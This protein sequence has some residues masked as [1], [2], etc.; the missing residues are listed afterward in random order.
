MKF[1]RSLSQKLRS[2]IADGT[3]RSLRSNE[4]EIDFFSNDYLGFSRNKAIDQKCRSSLK[5]LDFQNGST[6]SRLISGNFQIHENTE[7]DLAVFFQ[8]E[9]ALLFNS[10]YDANLGLLSAILQRNDCVFYD[11]LAH[12]S[13]RDGIQLSKASS[14]GFDHNDMDDLKKKVKKAKS[15]SGH[16]YLVVESVYSMDGDEAPLNELATFCHENDLYLIVDEAHATGVFGKQGRGLVSELGLERMVFA[17]VHTFGKAL[18]CHGAVVLGS[19]DL[20]NYLVNFSRS[21]I[22]TTAMPPAEVLRIKSAFDEL[23]V[24]DQM[25]KLHKI[26]QV[27]VSRVSELDLNIHFIK[28]R[29][30]IQSF[31]LSDPK[32][33][34]EINK[35]LSYEKIGAKVIL[36]PTVPNGHERIRICLH[37]FNS[38]QEVDRILQLLSTFV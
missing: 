13:I 22:Y 34:D 10:G 37:S 31:T 4:V 28:S 36:A 35:V 8:A 24:T 18:G 26:I 3:I 38:S 21:F 5:E 29:S 30:P 33:T 20:R 25:D 15:L 7:G 12:A 9:A 17:R 32:R 6:G 2:R 27:F 14:F 16:N 23:Q 1:P 19:E 11:R